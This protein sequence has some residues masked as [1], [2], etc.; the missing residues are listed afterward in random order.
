M[1]VKKLIHNIGTLN[2]N[3]TIFSFLAIS[4]PLNQE[5]QCTTSAVFNKM[6]EISYNM[7]ADSMRHGLTVLEKKIKVT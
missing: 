5:T 7:L 2:D 6:E 4:E 3:L 1:I